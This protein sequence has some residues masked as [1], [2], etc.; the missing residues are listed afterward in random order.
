MPRERR[1]KQSTD[2]GCRRRPGVLI[3]SVIHTNA[4][5]SATLPEDQWHQ[6]LITA[7]FVRR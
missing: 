2:A 4:M 5:C 6:T 1:E 7:P 3:G